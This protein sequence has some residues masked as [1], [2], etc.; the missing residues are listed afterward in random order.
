MAV[1]WL[2]PMWTPVRPFA[3]AWIEA[4]LTPG[5]GGVGGTRPPG[6]IT[7]TVAIAEDPAEGH[8]AGYTNIGEVVLEAAGL[9]KYRA[10]A[11]VPQP[12]GPRIIPAG[13]WVA[14]HHDSTWEPLAGDD[15][16]HLSFRLHGTDL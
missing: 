9:T 11:E 14:A 8:H 3:L 6:D 7:V 5:P 2:S 4:T 12:F 16:M 10:I 15:P 1:V 13:W